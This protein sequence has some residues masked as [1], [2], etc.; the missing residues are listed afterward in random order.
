MDY[1]RSDSTLVQNSTLKTHLSLF[2][3]SIPYTIYIKSNYPVKKVNKTLLTK[4]KN[5]LLQNSKLLNQTH[6]CQRINA[7]LKVRKTDRSRFK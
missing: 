3:L 1:F 2:S 6:T 4:Y 5:N 7:P